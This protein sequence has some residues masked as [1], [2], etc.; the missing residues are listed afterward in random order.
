[1]ADYATQ[2]IPLLWTGLDG[3]RIERL[4]ALT[5]TIEKADYATYPPAGMA[6]ACFS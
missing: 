3:S 6:T 5:S 1:M 2:L 4:K